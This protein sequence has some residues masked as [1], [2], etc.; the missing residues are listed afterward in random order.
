MAGRPLGRGA[1]RPARRG[2]SQAALDRANATF[3]N[4]VCGTALAQRLGNPSIEEFDRAYLE[5]YPWL[6]ETIWEVVAP[7]DTVLEVG[8]GY[9]TVAR[10]V[11]AR[12][13]DLAGGAYWAIDIA[14][15][16]IAHTLEHTCGGALVGNVLELERFFSARLFD[17]VIA[18]GC[19][20]HTG[21][22]PLGI[23]QIHRVLR[24]GG[25]LL[26]MIYGE[27]TAGDYDMHGNLAPFTEWADRDRITELF[28]GFPLV[29]ISERRPHGHTDIYVLAAKG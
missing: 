11:C 2:V 29:Q 5:L 13:A 9:G 25:K 3:W 14:P 12:I 4:H 15:K 8:P 21:N 27:A 23:S 16:V 28:S 6:K 19:L 26:A 22:L 7:G 24:P 18:I 10:L 17:V 20:H 1:A